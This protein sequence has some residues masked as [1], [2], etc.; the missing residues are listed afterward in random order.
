V[1]GVGWFGLVGGVVGLVGC[2]CYWGGFCV[3]FCVCGVFV[4]IVC[5]R[6]IFLFSVSSLD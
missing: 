4:G 5:G 1:G 3:G 6:V 2:V